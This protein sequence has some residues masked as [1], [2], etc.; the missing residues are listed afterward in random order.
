M[1][2][3]TSFKIK[4]F[5]FS[6]FGSG[7]HPDKIMLVKIVENNKIFAYFRAG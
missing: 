7:A 4:I 3:T 6:K 5:A 2:E 1:R